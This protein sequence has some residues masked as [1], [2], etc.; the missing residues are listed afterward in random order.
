MSVRGSNARGGE[1]ESQVLRLSEETHGNLEPAVMSVYIFQ[2]AFQT[3][4]KLGKAFFT[5]PRVLFLVTAGIRV[6]LPSR[7][8]SGALHAE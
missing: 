7:D 5:P 6:F 2:D 4:I 8:L 3:K 1:R